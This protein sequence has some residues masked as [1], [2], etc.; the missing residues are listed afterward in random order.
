MRSRPVQ[1]MLGLRF[2]R[3]GPWA[4]VA[5]ACALAALWLLGRRYAGITHD[6]TL[7]VAQGLR[8]IDAEAFGP[9]LFFKFGAQDGYTVFPFLYAPLIELFGVGGAAMLVTILGQLVFVAAAAALVACVATGPARWWSL[10]LLAAI[11]GY[12]GGVGTFRV[13]EPFA[14][15][16]TIAEPLVLAAIVFTL[17]A[18]PWWA[19][20]VLVCAAVVHPLVTVPGIAAVFLWHAVQRPRLLWAVPVLLALAAALAAA[21]PGSTARFDVAWLSEVLERS[22]HLF[23]SRWLA[24]DWARLFWGLCCAWLALRFVEAPVRHMVLTVTGTAIAGITVTWLAVD[25]LDSALAAGLQIWRAHWLMQV[26]V[27]VLV[28]VSVAG[29]W[30]LG[31]ASRAAAALLAASCCFGRADLPAAASLVALAV[32]LERSDRR[33]PGWMGRKLLRLAIVVAL[34]AA[35][36]GVLLEVQARLP[37]V[38]GAVLPWSWTD[39]L[40]AIAA[41]GMLVLLACL[42]W[43]AAC[44]RFP[45]PAAALACVALAGSVAAW[46][47]RS[48]WSR[49]IEQAGDRENPFRAALPSGTQVF[50]PAP[51]GPVWIALRTAT[52]FSVDQGAGI[53]FNRATA[54]EYGARKLA[55]ESL[56][57]RIQ[58]CAMAYPADCRIDLEVAAALCL[59][60]GRGPDYLVLNGRVEGRGPSASWQTPAVTG[61]GRPTLYLYPCRDLA[62]GA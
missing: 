14:T 60:R 41:A 38:Y 44:S 24:P 25:L 40:P 51:N 5:L 18:R 59:W 57:G 29:L 36:V 58:N 6:A 9:D 45:V 37:S 62:G 15:A 26:L 2:D 34:A 31:G 52:W 49:F 42:F 32:V 27:I 56:R 48:S 61:P 12:Y 47:G 53:A 54:M 17:A 21:V 4:Q 28:P 10:A 46:D 20:L 1:E 8:Q 7:Y 33:W 11:S 43:L 55:S 35:S 16:R 13:A 3:L 23:I 39:Y 30:R 50:W 22:P 19:L